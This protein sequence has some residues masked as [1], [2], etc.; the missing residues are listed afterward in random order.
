VLYN[1]REDNTVFR[2]LWP[3]LYWGFCWEKENG[4]GQL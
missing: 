4:D 1:S 2:V 3:S